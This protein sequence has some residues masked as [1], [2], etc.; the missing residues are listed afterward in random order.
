MK[1]NK[2]KILQLLKPK[3]GFSIFLLCL[4]ISILSWFS[5]KLSKEYF[6]PLRLKIE[7]SNIPDDVLI[8]KSS[9]SIF[10]VIVKIKG[11]NILSFNQLYNKTSLVIDINSL[12]KKGKSQVTY[13]SKTL[14]NFAKSQLNINTIESASADSI[15]LYY[16]KKARKKVPIISLISFDTKKQ[17]FNSDSIF[18]NPDSVWVYG[19]DEDVSKINYVT[20]SL[21]HFSGL[22]KP[23]MSQLPLKAQSTKN[24]TIQIFPAY[25]TAVIPIE[26]YTESTVECKIQSSNNPEFELKTFPNTV[27]ITYFVGLS[28]YKSIA[29]SSFKISVDLSKNITENRAPIVIT[30][31]PK[32]V[33]VIKIT[34]EII[35]FIKIKR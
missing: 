21:V 29:D 12:L 25:T 6:I 24:S 11:F 9:D 15:N 31:M 5:L 27:K 1:I 3:Y 13:S 26:K 22:D 30:Q 18:F 35:E 17:Y 32:Y 33:K 28:K 8:K 19:T 16:C 34:P 4:F 2:Q 7:Y 20:T 10:Q 14:L 23:F